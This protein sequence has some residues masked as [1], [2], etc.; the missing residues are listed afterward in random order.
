MV[1]I[2]FKTSCPHCSEPVKTDM[3]TGDSAG[4]MDNECPH[5]EGLFITAWQLKAVTAVFKC[6]RNPVNV[7]RSAIVTGESWIHDLKDDVK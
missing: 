2:K 1:E 6:D 4:T 7:E 3:S 5:C